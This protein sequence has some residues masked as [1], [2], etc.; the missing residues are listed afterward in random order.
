[1][2]RHNYEHLTPA[3]NAL[4]HHVRLGAAPVGTTWGGQLAAAF[5]GQKMEGTYV[6]SEDAPEWARRIAR[7]ARYELR[8]NARHGWRAEEIIPAEVQGTGKGQRACHF[9]HAMKLDP[10]IFSG[11]QSYN[12]C[13]SWATREVVGACIAVD[14]VER[15][16]LIEYT[17]RPGTAGIYAN[18]GS[19]M[20][21]GESLSDGA[22]A[23]HNDGITLETSYAG[24]DLSSQHLDEIAGVQWGGGGVP[25]D[26]AALVK[27][28]LIEQIA[29][30]T[31]AEAVQ[32]LLFAGHFIL[33]GSTR[34]GGDGD[35]IASPRRIGGHAQALI[36]YDD[37]DETR[38]WIAQQTGRKVTDWLAIFDQS[39]GNWNTVTHWP[40][41]FWGPKP[42]GAFVLLGSD[43][44]PMLTGLGEALAF[45]KTVG[46]PMRN[47]PDWGTASYL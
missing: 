44:M 35:P 37:T 8:A 23:V 13:C 7:Y 24:H 16:A 33:T 17:H 12:N 31:T 1:M 30:V 43:A 6:D 5:L 36:G 20:D 11:S 26:L 10:S 14:L 25:A 18:R 42:E 4:N 19:R 39:W 9:Q 15:G 34:T 21:M 22:A 41:Q 47:L 32:D 38:A 45:N 46:F 29:T 3:D 2:S 28:N 40:E 27:G